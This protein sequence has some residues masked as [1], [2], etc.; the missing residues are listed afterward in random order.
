MKILRY[1]LEAGRPITHFESREARI[2][3]IAR[4]PA[5]AAVQY[6][7]IGP[8]GVVGY[9]Q[10]AQRQLF[11]VVS[12]E[13]WVRGEGPERMPIAAGQAAFWEQGEGHESGSETGMSVVVIEARALDPQG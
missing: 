1:E 13:G 8:R 3:G 10:A 5:G 2:T 11:L 4:L 9:H 6:L 12:G 7:S